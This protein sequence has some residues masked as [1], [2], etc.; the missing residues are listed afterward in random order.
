M[1]LRPRLSSRSHVPWMKP[2]VDFIIPV[3]KS[4]SASCCCSRPGTRSTWKPTACIPASFAF[5][6]YGHSTRDNRPGHRPNYSAGTQLLSAHEAGDLTAVGEPELVQDVLDVVRRRPLGQVEPL[7]YGR[8][9]E[10]AGDE[11]RPL[12]FPPREASRGARPGARQE[13]AGV[14]RE[15][16]HPE[17]VRALENGG[18]EGAYP[19]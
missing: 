11:L 1:Q 9:R 16:R 15:R 6:P 17:Q 4:S 2:G 8:F 3:R 12:P 7:G 5:V 13:G 18:R 14:G 10:A 19:R